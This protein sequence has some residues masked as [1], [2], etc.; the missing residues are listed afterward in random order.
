MS[1]NG[2]LLDE[3]TKQSKQL[4]RLQEEFVSVQNKLQRLTGH[5]SV[6]NN[7]S[8]DDCEDIERQLKVSLHV[9]EE[10]KA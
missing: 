6:V 3:L 10:K 8:I 1:H 5:S 7:L 9:V 4:E 2:E